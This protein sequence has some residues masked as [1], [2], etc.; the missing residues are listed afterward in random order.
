MYEC[1]YSSPQVQEAIC[2]VHTLL[3]LAQENGAPGHNNMGSFCTGNPIARNPTSLRLMT[4]P[5]GLG[6]SAVE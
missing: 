1:H 5:Q 3:D 2:S 6:G 4:L